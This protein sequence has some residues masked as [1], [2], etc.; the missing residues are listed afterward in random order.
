MALWILL[1]L[2]AALVGAL[3]LAGITLANLWSGIQIAPWQKVGF[4]VG[5]GITIVVF[6][7]RA[8]RLWQR[9]RSR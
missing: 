3:V 4:E 9:I 1:L 7:I 8:F 2:H 6:A 5:I